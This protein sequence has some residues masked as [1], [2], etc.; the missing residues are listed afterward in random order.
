MTIK[1]LSLLM[2]S[3][4]ALVA[5][6]QA[7]APKTQITDVKSAASEVLDSKMDAKTTAVLI[8]ADWCGSCKVLDPMVKK[9]QAMGAIPGLN[10]VTLDYTDKDTDA[11]YAQ[12]DAAGVGE[13]V[14]TYLDGTVKTG[15]LVLVDM[16]DQKILSKVTKSFKPAEILTA[17]KEAV[18]AS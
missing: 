3:F 5:C 13:A 16:D 14:K 11:F 8:Y 17:L 12:A 1:S 15:Q 18:A 4:L 10:F 7:E 9:V 2:G 6:S